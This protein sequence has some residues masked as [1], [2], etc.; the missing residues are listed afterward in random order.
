MLW[1]RLIFRR[2]LHATPLVKY[3]SDSPA[4]QHQSSI[5]DER[6]PDCREGPGGQ[7]WFGESRGVGRVN[8]PCGGWSSTLVGRVRPRCSRAS[9]QPTGVRPCPAHNLPLPASVIPGLLRLSLVGAKMIVREL[10]SRRFPLAL[11]ASPEVVDLRLSLGTTQ[12]PPSRPW[13]GIFSLHPSCSKSAREL[14]TAG[15][16]DNDLPGCFV[17]DRRSWVRNRFHPCLL[18]TSSGLDPLTVPDMRSRYPGTAL[19]LHLA[20]GTSLIPTCEE[21]GSQKQGVSF[22][23][24][25]D[26]PSTSFMLFR[27]LQ[28]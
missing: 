15:L 23:T 10:H 1:A 26:P 13:L 2:C 14:P 19:F 4:A 17:T 27:V 5:V 20:P 18:L 7:V 16:P 22:S 9:S 6:A 24:L 28:P 25:I 11:R 8:D 21:A 12:A 3:I